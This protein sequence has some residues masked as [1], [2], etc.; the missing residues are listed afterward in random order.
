[1]KSK[2]SVHSALFGFQ[3]ENII[4]PKNG[5]ASINGREYSYPTLDDAIQF[6]REALQKHGIM[7]TQFGEGTNLVTVLHHVES[8]TEI[9]SELPIGAPTSSQDLGSRISYLRRYMYNAILGLSNEDLDG[10]KGPDL[11]V[12]AVPAIPAT[13]GISTATPVS[14]PVTATATAMPPEK[15]AAANP[16][17]SPAFQRAWAAVQSADSEQAMELVKGQLERSQKLTDAEKKELVEELVAR[18]AEMNG[19][20]S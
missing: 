12:P 13:G 3:G 19:T 6:T 17:R 20:I 14:V 2:G 18:D 4:L 1:M 8:G 11:N 16:E 15:A 10:N 7:L 9:R 5:K